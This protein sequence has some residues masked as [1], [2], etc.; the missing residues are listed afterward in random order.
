MPGQAFGREGVTRP[1]VEITAVQQGGG[2]ERAE[3]RF[4]PSDLRF[5]EH[6]SPFNVLNKPSRRETH[7]LRRRS[8][9]IRGW[10]RVTPTGSENTKSVGKP[11]GAG[12]GDV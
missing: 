5:F 8:G 1:R 12:R 11:E 2:L 9:W 7:Y 6:G 10:A 4:C 3:C